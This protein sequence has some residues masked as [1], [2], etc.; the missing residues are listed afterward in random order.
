MNV[1]TRITYPVLLKVVGQVGNHDLSLRWDTVLRGSTLL[2][3]TR[4][5]VLSLLRIDG[6]SLGILLSCECFVRGF[7]EWN[8][9]ARYICGSAIGRS[10]SSALGRL[11]STLDAAFSLLEMGNQQTSKCPTS[12]ATTYGT[13]TTTS[14]TA[15]ASS[16]A[17]SPSR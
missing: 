2:A 14:A 10:R 8:N 1:D 9:L 3:L 12:R 4:T 5:L 17:T 11:F 13:S 16:T 7:G 15:A 6:G